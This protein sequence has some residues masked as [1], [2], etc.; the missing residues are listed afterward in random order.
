MT[1][2]EKIEVM[3]AYNRGENIQSRTE[4]DPMWVK[5]TNPTWNFDKYEYRVEPN[6]EEN[7]CFK[8]TSGVNVGLT[9]AFTPPQPRFD[10]IM[11]KS[12]DAI[13]DQSERSEW[14]KIYLDIVKQFIREDS[15][16]ADYLD[17]NRMMKRAN[18]VVKSMMEFD[19]QCWV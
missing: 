2:K 5:D 1:L 6:K 12:L 10:D 17:I 16:R 9:P 4:V 3:Q 15:Q 8:D 18:Q 13:R 19:K 14:R 7:T 11:A